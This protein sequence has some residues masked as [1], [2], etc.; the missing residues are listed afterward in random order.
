M[1]SPTLHYTAQDYA[2]ADAFIGT[3]LSNANFA[4]DDDDDFGH[5]G[6]GAQTTTPLPSLGSSTGA[7]DEEEAAGEDAED[8]GGTED[9]A[10]TVQTSGNAEAGGRGGARR[11]VR[12]RSVVSDSG[13]GGD[14]PMD[15]D[16]DVDVDV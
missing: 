16:V 3:E 11:A 7:A 13:S 12:S 9:A 15:V 6:F 10:G 4:F 5:D 14:E 2:D 1:F 8:G